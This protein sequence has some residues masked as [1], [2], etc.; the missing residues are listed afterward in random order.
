LT[1]NDTIDRHVLYGVR[2]IFEKQP[3]DHVWIDHKWVVHDLLPLK[4]EKGSG[5]FPMGYVNLTPLH[6]DFSSEQE[7][8]SLYM[9]DIQIDIHHAEAEAYAENMQSSDPS[10][11]IVLR[12][13]DHE[14]QEDDAN[15]DEQVDVMLV[16]VSLSPYNI[17]DYEDCGEDQII[18]L[19]LTGPMAEFVE[20]FVATFYQPEE[21]I[22]RKRDRA[23]MDD[24][25]KRGGDQRIKKKYH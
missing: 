13:T 23:R 9:A 2:V 21:F 6:R 19:P 18:K 4:R 5:E 7:G 10:I 20:E 14:D 15:D 3:V 11:Y 22:K 16:E 1:Q 25:E 12:P 8:F 24:L 17:Q